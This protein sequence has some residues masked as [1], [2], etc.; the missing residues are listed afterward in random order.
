MDLTDPLAGAVRGRRRETLGEAAWGRR[1]SQAPAPR[2]L[3]AGSQS[4]APPGRRAAAGGAGPGF[5]E[6]VTP[7]R[8]RARA[9]PRPAHARGREGARPGSG[10]ARRR[11]GKRRRR[12]AEGRLAERAV[13]AVAAPATGAGAECGA[14]EGAEER[15]SGGGG[16]PH[17]QFSTT[18]PEFVDGAAR[19]RLRLKESS[20]D[21]RRGA[22]AARRRPRCEPVSYWGPLAARVTVSPRA[23]AARGRP[24]ARRGA[25]RGDPGPPRPLSTWARRAEGRG[26][27]GGAGGEGCWGAWPGP[28]RP[29]QMG[30]ALPGPWLRGCGREGGRAGARQRVWPMPRGARLSPRALRRGPGWGKAGAGGARGPFQ[31]PGAVLGRR[32]PLLREWRLRH[33]WRAAPGA[34]VAVTDTFGVSAERGRFSRLLACS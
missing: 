16:E 21:R 23:K 20:S 34:V 12:A 13:V 18:S 33:E 14:R 22:V 9:P 26:G 2:A 5:A 1:R 6:A 7:P 15:R 11:R 17:F 25:P 3:S 31:A 29:A 28:A 24:V 10:G 32:H 30:R 27:G 8:A 19:R 4:G